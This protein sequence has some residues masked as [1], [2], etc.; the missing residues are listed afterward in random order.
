MEEQ[1]IDKVAPK[2]DFEAIF[3]DIEELIKKHE[4]IKDTVLIFTSKD[5]REP[6][7]WFNHDHFYDAAR[8]MAA[9]V[10][11]IKGRVAEDLDC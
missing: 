9:C 5:G 3:K 2:E 7:F 8:L 11:Q 6:A 10:K 1:K 4:I